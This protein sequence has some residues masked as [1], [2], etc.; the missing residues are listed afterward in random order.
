MT[1]KHQPGCENTV[2]NALLRIPTYSSG[3]A[4]NNSS[5]ITHLAHKSCIIKVPMPL[6]F[7]KGDKKIAN[8]SFK[9]LTCSF[10]CSALSALPVISEKCSKCGADHSDRGVIA[11]KAH[12]KHVFMNSATWIG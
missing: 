2:P 11:K 8:L 12:K 7:I 1:Y 6:K 5:E 4:N 9:C 3:F 10:E